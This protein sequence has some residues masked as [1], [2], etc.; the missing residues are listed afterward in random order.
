MRDTD[1]LFYRE[2]IFQIPDLQE[3][4]MLKDIDQIDENRLL[5][6]SVEDLCDYFEDEFKVNVPVILDDDITVDCGETK[7]DVSNDY[8]YVSVRRGEQLHIDGSRVTFHIPFEGDSV[9]FEFHPSSFTCNPPRAK[10]QGNELLISFAGRDLN[11][12]SIKEQFNKILNE[13]KNNLDCQRRDFQKFHSLLREKAKARVEARR[14][15]ILSTKNLTASLGYKTRRREDAT[16]T[17]V[18]SVT[19][20]KPKISMPTPSTEPFVPE[21]E[22]DMQEYEHILGIITNMVSV[23]ER[24]PES[25]KTM[26]E[27]DLR[28]HF[29]VQL[30]GQYEGRATGETFNFEG[31]TDIL[32]R[33]NDKN[34]FIAECKFWRGAKSF[35][36]TINQLLGYI[37]WRDSKTAILL[38]NRNKN[39]SEILEKIPTLVKE[40]PYFKREIKYS[41]ETG[42]R[43]I[44]HHKDDRNREI[45][46]TILAFEVPTIRV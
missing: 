36:E 1:L 33:E 27:E 10:I 5:S 41:S 40:H 22:L 29:L 46:L 37:Q 20:K 30:N 24:S 39:F 3:R 23:I 34:I 17:Y 15:R 16:Q 9:L 26:K 32:I 25:F 4:E 12:Q 45:L 13:I 6:T 8:R 42:F 11:E 31:K 43:Y 7:I 35:T 28:Q 38:F 2:G 21:P 44:V 19:R 18:S 14:Q